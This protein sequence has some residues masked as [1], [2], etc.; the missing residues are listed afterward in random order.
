[1]LKTAVATNI[2][3]YIE[4]IKDMRRGNKLLWFRGQYDSSLRLIPKA[5][6]TAKEVFDQFGNPINPRDVNFDTKGTSVFYLDFISMLTEFKSEATKYMK[7]IPENDLV[8]LSIAQHYGL[9]TTLLDWTTDPLVAL[10]FGM[11]DKIEKTKIVSIDDAKNEFEKNEYSDLGAAVYAINPYTFNANSGDIVMKNPKPLDVIK[12]YELL[13]GYLYPTDQNHFITPLCIYGTRNER[14]I[15]RQSGNFTIH[16]SM[17]WPLDFWKV[18]QDNMYKIFIPYKC[19]N[20]I[21]KNL[22]VLDITKMS[23]YGKYDRK[24]NI[25]NIIENQYKQRFDTLIKV[26]KN[27]HLN[28]VKQL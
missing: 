20:E 11:P 9:P 8:W 25:S 12:N 7:E 4:A 28:N 22:K 19:I 18:H 1:M 26:L 13:K 10:F 23:I 3:E 27:K 17:V 24:D 14:R 2:Y 21:K 5:I 6:R 16:G 15:C